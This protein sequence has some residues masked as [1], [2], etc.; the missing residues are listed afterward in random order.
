[1]YTLGAMN[2]RARNGGG[3]SNG[4]TLIELLVVLAIVALLASLLLPAVSRAR[5]A[6]LEQGQRSTPVKK[7]SR[8]RGQ[9]LS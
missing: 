9:A 7:A 5:A 6:A 3:E 4:F 8:E 2:N 1:M